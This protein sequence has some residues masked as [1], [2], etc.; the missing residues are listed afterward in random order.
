MYLAP[1]WLL[2]R[3]LQ[4]YDQ[5]FYIGGPCLAALPLALR[6]TRFLI[7]FSTVYEDE[8]EGKALSGDLWAAATL[9]SPAW[10]I[11]RAQ[12]RFILRRAARIITHSPYTRDRVLEIQP[13]LADRVDVALVPQDPA[14]FSPGESAARARFGAYVLAVG[15]MNDPRKNF[16]LLAKAFRTVRETIPDLSLVVVGEPPGPAILD[17]I[18]DLGL[19]DA[20]HFLGQTDEETLIDTYRGATCFALSSTQEGLGI[21]ALEAMACGVPVVATDCGGPRG[22]VINGET[23]RLVPNRDEAAF[24]AA[25]RDLL[26][27]PDLRE[28]LIA[29]ALAYIETHARPEAVERVLWR[30]FTAVFP[31]SMA[32]RRS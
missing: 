26:T 17:L 20:V 11:V 9:Y 29:G 18:A 7:W 4:G 2:G 27:Q 3:A 1:Q 16:P 6:G 5:H 8:I 12:E 21:V 24:A 32:A 13:G 23:G 31:D 15:R 25:L 10:K 14:R 28:K 19:G 30:N 22:I